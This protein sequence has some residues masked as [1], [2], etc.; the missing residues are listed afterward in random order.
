MEKSNTTKI[1]V[2]VILIVLIAGFSISASRKNA[3]MEQVAEQQSEKKINELS[4]VSDSDSIES[5][6]ADIQ[7]TNLDGLAD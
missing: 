5:L 7:A 1:I 2:V 6:D 4:I 3:K